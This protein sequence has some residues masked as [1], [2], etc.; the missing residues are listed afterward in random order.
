[1]KPAET[2]LIDDYLCSE[3]LNGTSD[4]CVVWEEQQSDNFENHA[5][6]SQHN[7]A[8]Y[9]IFTISIHRE[10]VVLN[11]IFGMLMLIL[12]FKGHLEKEHYVQSLKFV[13][14]LKPHE[15]KIIIVL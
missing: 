5:V 3:E 4:N 6:C 10:Q 8:K 1:M 14:S 15:I 11:W 13:S 12:F 7:R 2:L 9:A